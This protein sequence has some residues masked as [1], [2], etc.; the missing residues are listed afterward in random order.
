MNSANVFYFF[1]S[2]LTEVVV[3]W[4]KHDLIPD[5]MELLLGFYTRTFMMFQRESTVA[6]TKAVEAK[7]RHL[8]FYRN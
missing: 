7:F 2:T 6:V 3:E 8:G 5:L 4:V 1:L